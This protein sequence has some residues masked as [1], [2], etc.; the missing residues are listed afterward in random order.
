[1]RVRLALFN[2]IDSSKT[3]H[4]R[5][6]KLN[7]L[8]KTNLRKGRREIRINERRRQRAIRKGDKDYIYKRIQLRDTLDPNSTLRQLIKYK[9]GEAPVIADTGALSKSRTQIQAYMHSKGYFYSEVT[10]RFDTIHRLLNKHKTKKK[11]IAR[12]N[13]TTGI[14]YYIDTVKVICENLSVRNDF[15]NFLKKQTDKQGLNADF[16][17]SILEGK[18][19]NLPFD[20]DKF[21]AY[22]T[23]LARYMRDQTYFGFIPTNISY[24]ADTMRAGN[25][26]GSNLKMSLTIVFGDRAVQD[27]NSSDTIRY[28][29]HVSTKIQ[30]VYFHFCD[31]TRYKGNFREEMKAI[32]SDLKKNN[33]LITKDSFLY[34]ELKKKVEDYAESEKVGHKVIVKSKVYHT[35]YGKPKDSI[36]FD[37][38]RIATF[39]YNGQMFVHPNVIESQNYLENENYYKEYY[40]ERSFSRLVQL[41]LF[42]IIKPEII[43]TFPGSGIVEVHYYLVPV[44]KQSFSFEPRAKNSN[45]FLGLTA[46]LNYSNKNIFR[47]GTNFTFS[48]SGGFESNPSVFAKDDTGKKVKTQGRSFNTIEIGPSVKLDIPGLFPFGVNI[49]SKRQ[50]PRTEL[51]GAYNYQKRPDFSR[52]L[53]QFNYLYKFL[54]GKTQSFSFGLPG[55]SVI[56]YVSINPQ[57]EFEAKINSLNDLYLKNA[58][59]NQFIWED[60]K[61]TFDFDNQEKVKRISPRLRILYSASFSIAGNLLNGLTS[62]NPKYDTLGH[63]LFLGVSYA[64]FTVFDNKLIAYLNVGKNKILAFRTM[65]GVGFPMK[66]SPTSLPYD[67]SFFGGGSNDNRGWSARTLGV[68]SYQQLLDPNFVITQIGDVRFNT[69]LEFRFGSGGVIN[70]ALFVDAGN[71]WTMKNDPNRP[72]GQISTRFLKELGVSVGYG[73]R[74]DFNYFIIRADLGIPIHN[75]SLPEGERWIY[76]KKPNFYAKAEQVYGPDYQSRLPIYLFQAR[77]NFGI[78]FPF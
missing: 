50:R 71:I 68:G 13:I 20:A 70:H 31:T 18:P 28:V 77:L 41:G 78:G 12:Y 49:L 75:P 74:L 65:A 43:E 19:I 42:S 4:G 25:N 59:R 66:N 64:Q 63:K 24:K 72:G 10:S 2:S 57:P 3:E 40:L 39:Y 26:K 16:K 29:K 35:I 45:G 54:V 15:N 67:Y 34:K 21:K 55:A 8:N 9:F 27:Q 76:S 7:R 56:K 30:N 52:G 23:E 1:M 36:D 61:I 33:F 62:I 37:K 11:V 58:Y 47:S 14:R 5:I 51:S 48:I 22:R 69:S 17:S 53:I 44:T 38:F 32:D 6:R 60:F 46:S 73:L